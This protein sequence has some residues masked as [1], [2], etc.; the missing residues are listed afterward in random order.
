MEVG[1]L[2]LPSVGSLEEK[3]K[4][5]AGKRTDLYQELLH[6]LTVQSQYLDEHGYYG[7]GF[8]E[9]HF[10]IEGSEV[11]NNPTLLGAYLGPK[12]RR[13]KW[14]Q[15]GYVLPSQHP[16]RMAEDVAM[17][18]QMLQGRAFFGIARGYQVRWMNNMGQLIPGL[19]D[20][21][22]F[23]TYDRVKRELYEEHFEIVLKAWTQRTF[24]HKGKHWEF[25]VPGQ[26][27]PAADFTRRLGTGVDADGVVT[28][29]GIAP[30]CYN[31]R[32][33]D[34]FQPFS[35]SL[36][37]L[38][39]AARNGLM[40]ISLVCDQD[41][42]R[43]HF[44]AFRDEAVQHGRQVA[45]GEQMGIMRDIVVADTDEEANA[46]AYNAGYQVWYDFFV[47][48]GFNEAVRRRHEKLEDIPTDYQTLCDRG[49]IIAGS[50]DT[51]CRKLEKLRKELPAQYLFLLTYTQLIPLPKMMRHW[52]L[53]TE[54]VLPHFTDRIR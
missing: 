28:E 4:G 44:T 10:H 21:R 5:F 37:S 8:T 27:W 11:S 3:L 33:P 41:L 48:F 18:D 45:Y 32:V 2:Y 40:P 46:L 31:N 38:R 26:V 16:I 24:T 20:A 7:A 29:I 52:E 13:M 23:E 50:P 36:T 14:G 42:V 30:P 35:F 53:L 1:I 25:P 6:D 49:L 34:M 17:L 19:R 12:T 22:D 15:L 54:K 39:W 47:P 9:H 51:V 43:E